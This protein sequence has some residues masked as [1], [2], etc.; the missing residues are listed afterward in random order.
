M[1]GR[2][3]SEKTKSRLA[4]QASQRGDAVVASESGWHKDTIAQ[5]RRDRNLPAAGSRRA[6]PPNE[7]PA[8][9]LTLTGAGAPDL[10]ISEETRLLPS[11]AS[12]SVEERR[13]LADRTVFPLTRE[14][15][16]EWEEMNQRPAQDLPELREFMQ[17]RS[18]FIL[19]DD[20]E[21]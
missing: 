18:E 19:Y 11:V 15:R 5:W 1:S 10:G 17:R 20:V 2:T 3:P 14:A 6:R 21:P 16:R 9:P 7:V 8:A 13:R 12:L 4:K